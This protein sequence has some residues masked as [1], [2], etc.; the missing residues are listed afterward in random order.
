MRGR[1]WSGTSPTL[2]APLT[3]AWAEFDTLV[4]RKPLKEG[5]LPE[6]SARSSCP[7]C[8][9]VPTWDAPE[10]VARVI[11]EGTRPEP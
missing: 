11:L 3:L 7:D 2:E 10:L 8:G 9:H 5:I 4:R 1:H 6:R